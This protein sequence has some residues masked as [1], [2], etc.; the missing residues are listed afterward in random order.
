[1]ST[2]DDIINEA[3]PGPWRE[4]FGMDDRTAIY[5]MLRSGNTHV[6][7][8]SEGHDSRFIA[9]FDP[10]HI[11]LMEDVCQAAERKRQ[12]IFGQQSLYAACTA[13]DAYRKERGLA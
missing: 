7:A 1:M 5:T 13:L 11:R 3:T 8:R 9:A 12:R 6:V 4:S 10:E 2:I